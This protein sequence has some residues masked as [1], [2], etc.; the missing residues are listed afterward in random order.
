V[1]KR[2]AKQRGGARGLLR[3]N[4]DDCIA[5]LRRAGERSAHRHGMQIKFYRAVC[6]SARRESIHAIRA[7][8]FKAPRSSVLNMKCGICLRITGNGF[9]SFSADAETRP[10]VNAEQPSSRISQSPKSLRPPRN[11]ATN[12]RSRRPLLPSLLTWPDNPRRCSDEQW[13]A[14]LCVRGVGYAIT[15]APSYRV[16]G[17]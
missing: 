15:E 7:K 3:Y 10:A 14:M 11:Q 1:K 5:P 4:H 2:V 9:N 6:L 12:P 16:T 8:K 17:S 13:R